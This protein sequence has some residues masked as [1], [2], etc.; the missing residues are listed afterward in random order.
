MKR[1]VWLPASLLLL[2]LLL[3]LAFWRPS[4]TVVATG[5][6]EVSPGAAPLSSSVPPASSIPDLSG[7]LDPAALQA[8]ISGWRERFAARLDHPVG[9]VRALEA[10]MRWLQSVYGEDWLAHAR[11]WLMQLAPDRVD[12]LMAR[13]EQLVAWQDWLKA[14]RDTLATLSKA[15][16]R[17]RLWAQREAIFGDDARVIWENQWRSEQ[18]DDQLS[19][20]TQQPLPLSARVD[21]WRRAID[22]VYGDEA[23]AVRQ[24]HA[25]E[26]TDRFLN[27]DAVQQDLQTLPATARYQVLRGLRA[28]MGMDEAALE[29][30]EALDKVRDERAAKGQAYMAERERLVKALSGPALETALDDLRR[31]YFGPQAGVIASEEASGFFRF[32]EPRRYGIN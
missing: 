29:R 16:R 18:L 26:L 1:T 9:Q 32:R 2:V 5:T 14:E 31:R 27:Q 4:A 3:A 10:L 8:F 30:W 15:E 7:K 24:R 11:E 21:A 28:A 25:Q 12:A 19:A 23:E 22:E 6:P 17:A 20:I 13:L